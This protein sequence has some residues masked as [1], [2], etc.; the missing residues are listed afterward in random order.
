MKEEM[1]KAGKKP[2]LYDT[3]TNFA[4]GSIKGA[5]AKE[6]I[7]PGMIITGSK[8]KDILQVVMIKEGQEFGGATA[9]KGGAY[10]RKDSKGDIK[11]IQKEEFKNAYKITKIPANVGKDNQIGD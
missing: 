3:D 2:D 1:V 5:P 9:G 11:M 4:S 10:L 7:K 8:K 6:S